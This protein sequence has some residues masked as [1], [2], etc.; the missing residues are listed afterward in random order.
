MNQKI[1]TMTKPVTAFFLLLAITACSP[2]GDNTPEGTASQAA[3]TI[4]ADTVA[5]DFPY[6][7]EKV[8]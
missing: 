7:F 8:A 6:A 5:N 2:S 4:T 3:N 1:K